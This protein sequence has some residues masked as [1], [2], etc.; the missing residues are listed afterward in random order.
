MG[1]KTKERREHP[2]TPKHVALS[3]VGEKPGIINKVDNISSSGVLCHT[4]RKLPVM[5]KVVM[6]V[7]LDT[8]R[9]SPHEI[10][11]IE[12]Q[13]VVVRCEPHP[14]EKTGGYGTAIFFTRMSEDHRA[15]LTSFVDRH[16]ATEGSGV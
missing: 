10:D 6:E 12:C 4:A 7:A 14:D 3:L 9:G 1:K 8:P 15:K 13:G 11:H 2:R 16:L 5:S